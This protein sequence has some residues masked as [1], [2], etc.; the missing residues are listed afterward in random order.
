MRVVMKDKNGKVVGVFV[1]KT[2]RG[3]SATQKRKIAT[4]RKGLA[5]TGLLQ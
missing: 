1:A 4:L 5:K 3:L 2:K